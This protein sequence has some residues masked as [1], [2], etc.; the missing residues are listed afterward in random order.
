MCN[1][2]KEKPLRYHRA[3]ALL[4]SLIY[5]EV[6]LRRLRNVVLPKGSFGSPGRFPL[7]RQIPMGSSTLELGL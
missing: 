6:I 4:Q 5:Q 7:K 1:A 3:Q 2:Y